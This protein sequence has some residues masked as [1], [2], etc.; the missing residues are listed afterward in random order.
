MILE[1]VAGEGYARVL[2]LWRDYPVAILAGGPSLTPAQFERVRIAR[3]ADLLRVIAVNDSYLLAPWADLHYAADAKW[4][5]WHR[6]GVAK[7]ALG[8]TAEQVRE[9]WRA[10]P[11]ERASIQSSEQCAD[12]RVKLLRNAHAPAADNGSGLSRDPGYLVT[13]WNSGF[14]ALN[15]AILAGSRRVLLLG[16]DAAPGP[17]GASHWHG[18]HPSAGGSKRFELWR[19]AFSAAEEAIRAAG[20]TVINCSPASAIESFQKAALEEVL[21]ELEGAPA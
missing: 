16:F 15:L 13:G 6:E 9:L 2:P 20:V 11:G 1:T 5:R 18:G 14:Q 10:F 7:P 12:P 3:A 8:L 17:N 4:H 21:A 19:R